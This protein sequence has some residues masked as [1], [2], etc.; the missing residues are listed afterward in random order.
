M[1]SFADLQPHIEVTYSAILNEI[2]AESYKDPL[3][4]IWLKAAKNY[5]SDGNIGKEITEVLHLGSHIIGV[6]HLGICFS[7][8][9]C[10]FRH[11]LL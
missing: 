3:W 1:D 2:L 4:R 8:D 7:F 11:H 6:T 5:W 10:K 9:L